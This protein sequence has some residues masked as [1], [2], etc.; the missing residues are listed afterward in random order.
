[1]DYNKVLQVEHFPG[2]QLIKA[3]TCKLCGEQVFKVGA[4]P[5]KAEV[6][7]E[8]TGLNAHLELR[9]GLEVTVVICDDPRCLEGH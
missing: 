7:V 4:Y 8:M 2:S 1:M 5:T 6:G 3:A 9:H